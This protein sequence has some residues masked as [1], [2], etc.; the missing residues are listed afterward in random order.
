MLRFCGLGLVVV[1]FSLVGL[2]F[3]QRLCKRAA[4]LRG[5][6]LFLQLFC[7]RIRYT[8]SPISDVFVALSEEPTLLNVSFLQ[9]CKAGI[10]EGLPFPEALSVAL[11]QG[12]GSLTSADCGI[13]SELS[14][15]I[16]QSDLESELS[17][18]ELVK[19]RL[20]RAVEEAQTEKTRLCKLYS[21]LGLLSG[22]AVAV[23]L[24]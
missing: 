3:S 7:E 21:S 17:A 20:S 13:L 10:L 1:F 22:V 15:C 5:C 23:L 18:L 16:G 11:E 12:A 8:L 24:A 14:A 6:Q 2:S 9:R 4:E 19:I